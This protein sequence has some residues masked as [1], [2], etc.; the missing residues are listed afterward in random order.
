MKLLSRMTRIRC[1]GSTPVLRRSPVQFDQA[2]LWRSA[3]SPAWNGVPVSGPGQPSRRSATGA[4]LR[5]RRWLPSNRR[6]AWSVPRETIRSQCVEVDM[7]LRIHADRHRNTRSSLCAAACA[8]RGASTSGST[9]L[10]RSPS[11]NSWSRVR[12]ATPD[13]AGAILA[14]W[15]R[16]ANAP[17]P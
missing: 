5:S 12:C 11:T 2:G 13:G 3:L 8:V 7:T 10:M 4:P 9:A 6:S 15:S 16:C 17:P 1:V 14:A